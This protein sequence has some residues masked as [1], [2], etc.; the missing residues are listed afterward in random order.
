MSDCV[1]SAGRA[2]DREPAPARPAADRTP[3]SGREPT[4]LSAFCIAQLLPKT[5]CSKRFSR[6][7]AS[8][9]AWRKGPDFSCRLAIVVPADIYLILLL[10]FKFR[11]ANMR[12]ASQSK[13]QAST[14][15]RRLRAARQSRHDRTNSLHH[16]CSGCVPRIS[17]RA[18]CCDSCNKCLTR[19]AACR[20]GAT[21]C[22]CAL[23]LRMR[24]RQK[25]ATRHGHV[26][27]WR[28]I[29]E[30]PRAGAGFVLPP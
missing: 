25:G 27:Q 14:T 15:S 8:I 7:F 19:L 18:L 24:N 4:G 26:L 1:T 17:R 11:V 23:M 28:C 22:F 29:S 10:L 30:A 6:R 12:Q 13:R 5:L 21:A 9:G 20:S 16:S 3:R 2:T